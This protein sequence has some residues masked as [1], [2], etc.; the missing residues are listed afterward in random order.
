MEQEERYRST[1]PQRGGR[2]AKGS[3]HEADIL[4]LDETVWAIHCAHPDYSYVKI[5]DEL[6]RRMSGSPLGGRAMGYLRGV[7][8][9]MKAFR[10]PK[11]S[12]YKGDDPSAKAQY[13]LY[14]WPETHKQGDLPWEST[15]IGLAIKARQQTSPTVRQIKWAHYLTLSAPDMPWFDPVG[16][17]MGPR[18]EWN[19]MRL[20][21]F[22]E[23]YE[24]I[25]GQKPT[26]PETG[27]MET[28]AGGIFY[29]RDVNGKDRASFYDVVAD[30][31]AWT[32]WVSTER[33]LE[34]ISDS[35]VRTRG[36]MSFIRVGWHQDV[37]AST[38]QV[39]IHL[40]VEQQSSMSNVPEMWRWMNKRLRDIE[41]APVDIDQL[42][43]ELGEE[44]E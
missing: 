12:K 6:I 25:L 28:H 32:P 24:I 15:A 27:P 3:Q 11:S 5:H 42:K 29:H 41:Y 9:A 4:Q 7:E 20:S 35:T 18:D 37:V 1:E 39:D 14:Q 10:N 8:R 36:P 26:N 34:Y 43:E 40:V 31:I 23:V 44:K 22:L 33:Y 30:Y 38:D 21:L 17:V 16:V 2:P 19:V 13:R